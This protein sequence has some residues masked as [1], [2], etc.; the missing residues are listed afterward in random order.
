[1]ENSGR[2]RPDEDADLARFRAE[3]FAAL[4]LVAFVVCFCSPVLTMAYIGLF[5]MTIG[6]VL[7]T[8]CAGRNPPGRGGRAPLHNLQSGMQV[9]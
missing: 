5:L 1:M 3:V 7:S 6:L 2:L 9:V 8:A 4:N